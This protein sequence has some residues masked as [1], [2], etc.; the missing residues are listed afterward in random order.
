MLKTILSW[1]FTATVFTVFMVLHGANYFPTAAYWFKVQ[2]V[3]VQNSKIGDSVFMNVDRTIIRSFTA[4]WSAVIRRVDPTDSTTEVVCS[5]SG[6][7]SYKTEAVLPDPLTLEWWTDG[8]CETLNQPGAYQVTTVWI[9]SPSWRIFGTREVI[10][11]SNI[12]EVE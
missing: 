10:V 12:F 4:Q 8:D 2:S 1:P 6:I 5:G 9:L 7:S 11:E 3:Q